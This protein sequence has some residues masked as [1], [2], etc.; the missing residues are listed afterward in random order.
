MG[1]R[2]SRPR[3]TEEPPAG[4]DLLA[5]LLAARG[6]LDVRREGTVAAILALCAQTR[7]LLLA[8]PSLLR[9][10]SSPGLVTVG[11]IHG[12]FRDLRRIFARFGLP[13]GTR[14]LF[15]GDYVDRGPA[16]LEVVLLLCALKCAF[17]ENVHLLRGNHEDP[18]VNREYGFLDE[19]RRRLAVPH[20]AAVHAAVN[21]V[22]SALPFAALVDGRVFC[23]HGGLSPHLRALGQ[24]A[25]VR[26]PCAV[27]DSGL[28]HDL[29]WSDPAGDGEPTGPDGWGRGRLRCAPIFA[30]PVVDAF[31]RAHGL[32]LVV[33]SHGFAPAGY[34]FAAG[35]RLLTV[36]SA[37][38]YG[39]R[40]NRAAVLHT[41][42]GGSASIH[43]FA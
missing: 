17:P 31:L 38:D 30:A 11:D 3:A 16:S 4:A 23:V 5:R 19:C 26:R 36:F 1:S 33:R 14:Y 39:G 41:A 29:L 9:I 35:G 12:Q 7:A 43:Q 21:G 10:S 20:A 24:I 28:L 37:P 15:L 25:A 40:G 13:P 8:G 2:P 18:Q 6:P 22:F 42:A 32:V 27:P 34:A